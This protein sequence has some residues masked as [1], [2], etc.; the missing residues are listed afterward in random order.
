MV[1]RPNRKSPGLFAKSCAR[2]RGSVEQHS[3]TAKRFRNRRGVGDRRPPLRE[4][5]IGLIIMAR[6]ADMDKACHAKNGLRRMIAQRLLESA[7]RISRSSS[8]IAR[9]IAWECY[10]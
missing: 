7:L 10:G 5:Q 3:G 4:S 9:K 6:T 1:R 8:E 2:W